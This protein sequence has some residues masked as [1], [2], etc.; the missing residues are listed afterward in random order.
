LSNPAVALTTVSRCVASALPEAMSSAGRSTRE[1]RWRG[2]WTLVRGKGIG[3]VPWQSPIV[4][5][6]PDESTLLW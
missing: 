3:D 4:R 6:A 2:G 1:S 5:V